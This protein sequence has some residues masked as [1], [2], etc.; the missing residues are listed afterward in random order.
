MCGAAPLSKELEDEV[1][2][3]YGIKCGQAYGNLICNIFMN[4]Y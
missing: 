1:L 2:Q 3:K 4:L